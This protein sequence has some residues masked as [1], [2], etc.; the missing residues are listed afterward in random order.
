[1]TQCKVTWNPREW[2]MRRS[3]VS[4]S[5]PAHPSAIGIALEGY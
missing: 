3:E 1:M 4:P 2:E 5:P